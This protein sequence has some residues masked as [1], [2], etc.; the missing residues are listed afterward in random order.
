[1]RIGWLMVMALS[2][3]CVGK[4]KYD[5]LLAD[6]NDA[7]GLIEDLNRDI[8]DLQGQLETTTRKLEKA[9]AQVETLSAERGQLMAD[10]DQLQSSVSEMQKALV[11]LSQRKAEA[12]GRINE[13]RNLISRFKALIDAGKLRVKIVDGRMVVEL[14]TDILF[15]SGSAQL[16]ANGKVAIQEVAM[17]LASIPDRRFQVEGHTDNVPIA[18]AQY[19]S[20]WELAAARAITV[21]KAMVEAGLPADRISAASFGDTRP[22]ASN[23][24]RETKA[25]NRRIEFIIVPDLSPLPGFEELKALDAKQ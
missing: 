10:Q 21:L 24:S 18:S 17:V 16:S 11:E 3:G 14:A 9:K 2:T 12:D 4:K 20:N 7:Q 1:M 22:V 6:Y 19:P 23:D 5:L 13:F 8:E 15:D 25:Q